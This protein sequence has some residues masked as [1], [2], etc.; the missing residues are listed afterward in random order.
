MKLGIMQP[1]IFPYIGYFQLINAVDKFIIFDDVNYIKKGWINRNRILLNGQEFMITIPL[2]KASQNKLIC[3]I[4]LSP[5]D[6]WKT[7]LLKTIN[8]AYKKA[9]QFNI[10]Y[11]LLESIID[12]KNRN[13]SI[14]TTNSLEQ[15]CNYLDIKTQII[16]SSLRYKTT[17]LKGQNKILEI[18]CTEQATIYINPIGGKEIYQK[19]A[20]E[21][22]QIKLVFLKSK[23]IKYDQFRNEFLPFLSII[24]L[25]MFNTKDQISGYLKEYEYV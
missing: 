14:F 20:F 13:L 4:D 21:E 23:Q 22:K 16:S 6:K 8:T 17:H 25:M 15:F 18:C 9:P 19:K 5:D 12:F 3:E 11:P 7:K 1:Y 24:D 10:A 2:D